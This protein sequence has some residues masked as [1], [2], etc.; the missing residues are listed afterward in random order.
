LP[1]IEITVARDTL[2]KE[3]QFIIAKAVKKAM[4]RAF[5]DVKGRTPG[6]YVIVREVDNETWLSSKSSS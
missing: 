1:L 3:E 6:S 4:I 2:N 5:E